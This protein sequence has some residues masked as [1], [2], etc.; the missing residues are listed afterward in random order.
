M[1]EPTGGGPIL[2]ARDLHRDFRMGG[3]VLQILRGVDF[4]VQR[5]QWATILGASGSGKSTLLHLLGA[6]DRPHRGT[7]QFEGRN[8]LALRGATLDR[9][10]SRH[11]GFIFQFYHLLPELNVLDNTLVAAM[12]AMGVGGW[13]R[14]RSALRRRAEETLTMLGLQDRLRHRP[15]KLSGGERQRV[16]IARALMNE[17]DVLL[18]DE[19]TGNLDAETGDQLLAILRKL[20]DGGQTIVMVT[21]DP[22]VADIADT[23]W[24]L[25]EGQIHPD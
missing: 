15:A 17:P 6:L 2:E 3:E 11:V 4:A 9:F 12:T 1:N 10:R 23:A 21:H 7:L 22:T 16:A 20:C 19:P 14:K 18:A 8:V 13:F 24:T 25:E 5:G